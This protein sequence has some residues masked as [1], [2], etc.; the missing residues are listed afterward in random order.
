MQPSLLQLKKMV[1]WDGMEVISAERLA[2]PA[3]R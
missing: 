2:S 1:F 3:R